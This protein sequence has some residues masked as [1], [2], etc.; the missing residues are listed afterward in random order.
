[1]PPFWQGKNGTTNG[2]SLSARPRSPDHMRRHAM[3][4]PPASPVEFS[5]RKNLRS[6]TA[7]WEASERNRPK[8]TRKD[9]GGRLAEHINLA[10]TTPRSITIVPWIRSCNILSLSSPFFLLLHPFRTCTAWCISRWRCA[11]L[12]VRHRIDM[13]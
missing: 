2:P 3:N 8:I 9:F 10:S 13:S 11:W 5:D 12:A 1:M 7:E 4:A 6:R